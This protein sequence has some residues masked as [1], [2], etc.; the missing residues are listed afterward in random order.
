[1]ISSEL[2]GAAANLALAL[3]LALALAAGCLLARR[4]AR[5]ALLLA[6]QRSANA[7]L[8][9]G[10]AADLLAQAKLLTLQSQRLASAEEAHHKLLRIETVG[11][12]TGGIAHD[13]NNVLMIISGNLQLLQ[14]HLE[15]DHALRRYI[16]KAAG[17][18]AN[19]VKLTGKLLAFSRIQQIEMGVAEIDPVI[20]RALASVQAQAGENICIESALDA[21]HACVASDIVQ[22]EQAIVNLL[23]NAIEAMPEGGVLGVT[24]EQISA[25]AA[26]CEGEDEARQGYVRICI[27]DTGTGMEAEVIAKAIEP[28]FTTKQ[29]DK[30][31]GLGLAQAYGVV[32]LSGGS[33]RIDSAPGRGTVLELHLLCSG[34]PSNGRAA[35]EAGQMRPT[36]TSLAERELDDEAQ[37]EHMREPVLIIDDDNGVRAIFVEALVRMGHRVIQAADGL[38]GLAALAKMKPSLA[39]IDFM[40]PGMNGDEVARLAR[41]THPDLAIIFISGYSDTQSLNRISNATLLRKPVSIE[42][43]SAAVDRAMQH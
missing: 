2:G 22:I 27:S 1:M 28:F 31:A 26:A 24:S 13:F 11:R 30:G 7:A 8:R 40:M 43:L 15:P 20:R 35:D 19:G 14:A 34:M 33:L 36:A 9:D 42:G 39:I 5:L 29:H 23:V 10:H 17:A 32:R 25:G 38:A 18:S 6:Q 4:H 41:Q 16:D 12:L 37:Q 3:L 21:G